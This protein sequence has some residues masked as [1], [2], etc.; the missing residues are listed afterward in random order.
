MEL[1]HTVN[2]SPEKKRYLLSISIEIEAE[3]DFDA[4][5]YNDALR[6]VIEQDGLGG[7]IASELET[8]GFNLVSVFV[9]EELESIE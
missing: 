3:D 7:D 5:M 9:G 1:F 4:E 2:K 6:E 8:N